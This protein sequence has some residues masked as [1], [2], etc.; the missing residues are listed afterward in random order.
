MGNQDRSQ[1]IAICSRVVVELQ[2]IRQK[3]IKNIIKYVMNKK[4]IIGVDVMFVDQNEIE[5][6]KQQQDQSYVDYLQW[7][8]AD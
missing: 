1:M 8:Y 2:R 5:L 7:S 4:G 3:I 6:W